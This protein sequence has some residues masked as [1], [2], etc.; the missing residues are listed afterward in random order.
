MTKIPEGCEILGYYDKNMLTAP[1]CDHP[2]L[3]F[4]Y[5]AVAMNTAQGGKWAVIACDLW[6]G[7]VPSTQRG[8]ILNIADYIGGGMPAKILSPIQA[9]LLPRI[10]ASGNTL[11]A[12]V[13][14]CTVGKAD[15]VELL[16]RRPTSERFYFMSQYNGECELCA[17]KTDDGYV[18]TIPR[19]DAWSVATVF[20]E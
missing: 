7:V 5:S 14:N 13:V 8:R 4:G 18:V 15:H 10:D 6:K 3:P 9:L 1:I 2:E 20:C 16:L 11:A 19:I 12:T 17:K